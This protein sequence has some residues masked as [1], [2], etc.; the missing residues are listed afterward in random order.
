MKESQV[1]SL[2]NDAREAYF[3]IIHNLRYLSDDA[4][5]D[6]SQRLTALYGSERVS[7]SGQNENPVL[8]AMIRA[9]TEAERLKAE[10]DMK[11]AILDKATLMIS[12]LP[13]SSPPDYMDILMWHYI[14]GKEFSRIAAI[15]NYSVRT[16]QRKNREAISLLAKTL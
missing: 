11:R 14:K 2:L 6:V 7:S 12:K 15:K 9:D 8:S 4:E 1:V 16:V 5:L 10:I 13:Q 3:R